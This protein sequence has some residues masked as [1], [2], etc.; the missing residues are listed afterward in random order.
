MTTL[1]T[2]V[3]LIL[4]KQK[5]LNSFQAV[6]AAKFAINGNTWRYFTIVHLCRSELA[7]EL[8]SR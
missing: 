1:C 2:V 3:P 6:I 4:F 5:V 7:R 8:S